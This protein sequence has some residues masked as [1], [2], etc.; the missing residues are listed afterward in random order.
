MTSQP[1]E[2]HCQGD[3]AL[4]AMTNVQ[5]QLTQHMADYNQHKDMLHMHGCSR[6]RKLEEILSQQTQAMNKWQAHL[7]EQFG[8]ELQKTQTT[9]QKEFEVKILQLQQ[10]SLPQAIPQQKKLDERDNKPE[11]KPESLHNDSEDV[12]LQRLAESQQRQKRVMHP[13][14]AA[15]M[16]QQN[17]Q[18]NVWFTK[19]PSQCY[20]EVQ[21]NMLGGASVHTNVGITPGLIHPLVSTIMTDRPKLTAKRQGGW[22]SFD[23]KWEQRYEMIVACNHGGPPPDIMV[24][25]DLKECLDEE[26]KIMLE[27]E[28]EKNKYLSYTEFYELL[29]SHYDKDEIARN[30]R[31]WGAL[32]LPNGELTIEKWQMFKRKFQLLR[33]RVDDWTPQEEYRNLTQ[34]LP[35]RWVKEVVKMSAQ[36]KKVHFLYECLG[37]PSLSR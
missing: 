20:S 5:V 34:V 31:A 30:R 17:A 36:N 27:H 18:G 23:Q 15:A 1:V 16:L 29:R 25:A 33:D 28:K 3:Q 10:T 19:P 4:T 21:V 37:F 9:M 2:H 7:Q 26:D 32:T 13:E 24:L 22:R 35:R 14:L 8:R 12:L 6:C 11:E